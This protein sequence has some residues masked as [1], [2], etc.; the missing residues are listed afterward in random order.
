[1]SVGLKRN[2][3]PPNK[4]NSFFNC[5]ASIMVS[6]LKSLC[7]ESL[8]KYEN[9]VC[10]FEV[11]FG[12][13]KIKLSWLN[14]NYE[15]QP[16]IREIEKAVIDPF[17]LMQ[18][19]VSYFSRVENCLEEDPVQ[20][21]KDSLKTSLPEA[22]ILNLKQNISDFLRS[23]WKLP[24]HLIEEYE[25]VHHQLKSVPSDTKQLFEAKD[26]LQNFKET[27]L[28]DL[29]AKLQNLTSWIYYMCGLI[30]F[31]SVEYGNHAKVF[32]LHMELPKVIQ[33]NVLSADYALTTFQENLIERRKVFI[34][35]L[36]ARAK[37]ITNLSHLGDNTLV[38]E[39]LGTATE[40][41]KWLVNAQDTMELFNAEELLFEWETTNYPLCQ[42][43]ITELK[44]YLQLYEYAVDFGKKRREWLEGPIHQVEPELVEQEVMTL[45]RLLYKL[46]KTFSD[47]RE[48]RRIAESVKSTV[49]KFKEYIPLVQTL[50][51]PG[52]RDRHWDQI[53]EIVG[54]PLKPD[55]STTLSKLIGLNLQEY[56]PQFEVISE[57][58]SKEYKLEKAMDKMM[59]EWSEMMFS[60]KPFRESG[61]HILS[62]VDEIQLL[63]D[64]H[65]IKT[66]TM[67]G[68]PSVKP[69]EGKVKSWEN[70]LMLL[71]EIIDA[72]LKVQTTWLYLEPIFSSPDIMAQM[73]EEGRRFNTVDKNW[74]E[75]MKAVLEDRHVLAVVDIENMLDT[76]K[77]SNELLDLIQ[78]GL[79]DYLEKKDF[80][81]RDSFSYLTTS[82]WKF[83]QKLKIQKKVQ[84]HLK[85]CFEGIAKLQFLENL[86]ITH[87]ESSEGEIIELTGIISVTSAKRSSGKVVAGIRIVYGAKY[88]KVVSDALD[89]YPTKARDEWI[90]EWPG[91]AVFVLFTK[92]LQRLFESQELANKLKKWWLLVRGKGFREAKSAL[93]SEL[94]RGFGRQQKQRD[95]VERSGQFMEFLLMNFSLS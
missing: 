29:K 39:Y 10:N 75:V 68:S 30:D 22:I 37:Q 31:T 95:V 88:K 9:Y 19:A 67:R 45:W 89:S 49:E 2:L 62:S 15:L 53:S 7:Y 27:S 21:A 63:L 51:N 80:I 12:T 34:E 86:D 32:S 8:C 6:Q 11:Y 26:W 14:G 50:C 74:R 38:E 64:D 5:V 79:N 69:I 54:F 33:E 13:I 57:A 47:T 91:Q 87:M 17:D 65:L 40:I 61:T 71:Q 52:L 90:L 58:A 77:T 66:Q 83:Y 16:E 78:K 76:L 46:E 81:S 44:P 73:P 24:L 20:S 23:K 59:E 56:I 72:W 70:K 84:P 82:F 28:L 1:M 41:Q 3:I 55:K 36:K 43:L 94:C 35:D 60:V 18:W 93:L 48:P 92:L 25:V 42:N 85:K 4:R